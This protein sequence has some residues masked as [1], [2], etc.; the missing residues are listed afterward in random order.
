VENSYIKLEK[1]T[2]TSYNKIEK[3][4]SLARL[5]FYIKLSHSYTDPEENSE[6]I[7]KGGKSRDN[8]RIIYIGID[9]LL[10][11]IAYEQIAE[12][13]FDIIEFF[14]RQFQSFIV[15]NVLMEKIKSLF[16]LST[17]NKCSK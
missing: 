4:G 9:M 6:N 8:Q 3:E 5:I 17:K 14:I 12:F 15:F 13:D 2:E 10:K 11:K 7:I 16:I 1:N